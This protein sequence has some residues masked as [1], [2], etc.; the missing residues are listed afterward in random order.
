VDRFDRR[1]ANAAGRRF[2]KEGKAMSVLITRRQFA[3]GGVLAVLGGAALVTDPL[4]RAVLAQP[5]MPPAS[6]PLPPYDYP[7]L[8]LSATADGFENV[9]AET[10]AGRYLVNLKVAEGLE[11]AQVSFM[12]PPE[13]HTVDEILGMMQGPPPSASPAAGESGGE[14]NGAPPSIFYQMT[15]AGGNGWLGG[16]TAQ[17]VLDLGP[18]E[19]IV[20]AGNPDATQA[21]TT[22]QVTGDMP[23]D[24]TDPDADIQVTFVDFAI[25]ID[26]SLTAGDHVMRIENDGAEPHFLDLMSAPDGITNDELGQFIMADV[27]GPSAT[28]AAG[29]Y[30]ESDFVPVLSTAIQSIGVVQWVPVTLA[31]GTYAAICWFPTAGTGEP[32]AMQGMHTVFTVE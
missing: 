16:S 10:A 28:P 19:W 25:S 7:T 13:G 30:S 15:F 27:N 24:L 17:A 18:G 22:M 29:G 2:R 5:G 31:A 14:D 1:A 3:A 20:W 9:P 23:T 12:K 6:N 26:G 32:H 21:P 8:D 4:A 11:Y